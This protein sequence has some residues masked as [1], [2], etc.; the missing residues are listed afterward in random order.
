MGE[1]KRDGAKK[2]DGDMYKSEK[3]GR[4]ERGGAQGRDAN[5]KTKEETKLRWLKKKS[6]TEQWGTTYPTDQRGLDSEA[7]GRVGR[8][9]KIN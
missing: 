9:H 4:G 7:R 5:T 1:K 2:K 8:T 3:G 6:E